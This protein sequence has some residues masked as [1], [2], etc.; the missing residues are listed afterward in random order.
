MEVW[1]PWVVAG[2]AFVVGLVLGVVGTLIVTRRRRPI[3]A[4]PVPERPTVAP[5]A[6]PA[7]AMAAQPVAEPEPEPEPALVA[8]PAPEPPAVPDPVFAVE[9]DPIHEVEPEP[10]FEDEEEESEELAAAANGSELQ[11]AL[12]AHQD[13]LAKLEARYQNASAPPEE[14]GQARTGKRKRSAASR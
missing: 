7:V 11:V 10:V 3:A 14:E 13:M 5:V 8:A 6:E 1:L 12:R 2:A 4:T 9:P